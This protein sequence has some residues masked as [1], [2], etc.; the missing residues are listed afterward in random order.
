[1]GKTVVTI[2]ALLGLG[3]GAAQADIYMSEAADGTLLLTNLPRE[4]REY[5]RVFRETPGAPPPTAAR[6]PQLAEQGERPYAELVAQAATANDLPPAL[7]HAVIRN[8]SNY[9]PAALSPKGAAGLMQLMPGTAREMGVDNV[10]DPA[11]NI[12]GGAR[13]LK[14]LLTQFDHDIPL[15]VAAYNA[16]PG[17]VRNSG[18]AIP[19]YPETQRYVPSVLLDY[20]RLQGLEP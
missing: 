1:M 11:A 3:A 9:D 6:A 17:A 20:R 13:Y 10:W 19:P 18:L 4:G 14:R 7:L 12:Q 2:L 16:G 8:E 15:A 5:Q